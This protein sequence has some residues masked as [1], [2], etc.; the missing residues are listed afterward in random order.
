MKYSH[1]FSSLCIVLIASIFDARLCAQMF[2]H[3]E[4]TKVGEW[5]LVKDADSIRVY[6]RT[7]EGQALREFKASSLIHAP[8]FQIVY[9]LTD[10]RS[11]PQWMGGT[12]YDIKAVGTGEKQSYYL[13]Y[14]V[15]TP[16]LSSDRDV[17]LKIEASP[18]SKGYIFR[19]KAAP[20][21]L[22]TVENYV[23]IGRWD[24]AWIV[25]T[26]DDKSARVTYIGTVDD[27]NT[28]PTK[29]AEELMAKLP[30][31]FLQGLQTKLSK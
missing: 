2:I 27:A 30:Y 9:A 19:C 31:E 18:M 14:K 26:V 11:F 6:N 22:P 17:I 5:E 28:L 23:R 12:L 20:D 15:K 10:Y 7:V 13:Y 3:D 8:V 21:Y 16:V 29:Y 24:A 25:E 4:N 1:I